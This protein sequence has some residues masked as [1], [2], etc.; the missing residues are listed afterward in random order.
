[1]NYTK[2]RLP[3]NS[4]IRTVSISQN[5]HFCKTT[6]INSNE[7]PKPI[8]GPRFKCLARKPR[9][10]YQLPVICRRFAGVGTTSWCGNRGSG[11]KVWQDHHKGTLSCGTRPCVWWLSLDLMCYFDQL[12][13][14]YNC[15]YTMNN[16]HCSWTTSLIRLYVEGCVKVYRL[17]SHFS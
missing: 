15:C 6:Q 1:M 9:H 14:L 11:G 5:S 3:N 17:T 4:S 10:L 16:N 8:K 13:Y 12:V 7:T 2:V